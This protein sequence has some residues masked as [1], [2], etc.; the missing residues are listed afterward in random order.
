MYYNDALCAAYSWMSQH[1]NE[2]HY[3][4]NTTSTLKFCQLS[5]SRRLSQRSASVWTKVQCNVAMQCTQQHHHQSST[6][7]RFM[8][9]ETTCMLAHLMALPYTL[10][11]TRV[12]PTFPSTA[13]AV[14][15]GMAMYEY[16]YVADGQ[17]TLLYVA[18]RCN[19]ATSSTLQKLREVHGLEPSSSFPMASTCATC[20]LQGVIYHCCHAAIA[21]LQRCCRSRQYQW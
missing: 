8:A 21:Q 10:Y 13:L 19:I 16:A 6:T 1:L 14:C 7:I 18:H 15:L 12:L 11:P 3:T 4:F 5:V 20:M 17:C 9:D 2:L